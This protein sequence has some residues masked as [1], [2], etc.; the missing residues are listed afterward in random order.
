[1]TPTSGHA[2]HPTDEAV[3]AAALAAPPPSSASGTAGGIS[4]SEAQAGMRRFLSA[5]LPW[6]DWEIQPD[7]APRAGCAWGSVR[8][9]VCLAEGGNRR[10]P[11]LLA[12]CRARWAPLP[13]LPHSGLPLQRSRFASGPTAPTGFW[14]RV[15]LA[16]RVPG[17]RPAGSEASSPLAADSAAPAH[18]RSTSTMHPQP[19]PL[20]RPA[21]RF[22]RPCGMAFSRWL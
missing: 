10:A 16:R 4:S 14:G 11:W 6:S 20:P 18:P 1:M 13:T 2:L 12:S 22:T 17:P 15:A 3:A 19:L 21:R 8:S 7:G 5:D 9:W